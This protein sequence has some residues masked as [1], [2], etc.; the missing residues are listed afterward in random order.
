MAI[1][2]VAEGL[3]FRAVLEM[4]AAVEADSGDRPQGIFRW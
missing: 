2:A 1:V 4:V 3:L